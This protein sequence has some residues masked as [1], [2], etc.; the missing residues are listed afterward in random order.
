[1]DDKSPNSSVPQSN[2]DDLVKELSRP[3]NY[4]PAS[5]NGPTSSIP[6]Q[7]PKPIPQPAPAPLTPSMPSRPTPLPTLPPT[8]SV[9][10]SRGSSIPQPSTPVGGG[11][12]TPPVTPSVP[13][14][15]QS[16]IRT[17]ADDMAKIKAGQQPQGVNIPRKIDNIPTAPVTPVVPTTPVPMSPKSGPTASMPSATKSAPLSTAPNQS[18][19][20]KTPTP[21]PIPR[22]VMPP[23]TPSTRAPETKFDQKNQF[24]VPPTE[25]KP[26][27]SGSNSRNLIFVGIAVAVVL[28]GGLYWYFMIRTDQVA[29]E[30]PI[31]TFTPRPTATPNPDVLSTIFT[32]RGGTIV[33]PQSGDPTTA[34]SN[35]IGAQPV[36]SQTFVVMDISSGASSSSAQPLTIS[37]LLNRF[38][39]SYPPA[40]QT[41]LGQN[42]KFL[43]YG[44]KE[45]FDSKGQPATNTIPGSRFV[46]ISEI[47]SSSASILQGWESTMSND[48]AGIMGITPAKNIGPF[49]TTNYSGVSVHFKNFPYP[50]HSIDYALMQYNGKTYLIIAGSREAM[51]ATID[52]F[53]VLGK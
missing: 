44:Q 32:T 16:S 20:P 29:M 47:A 14:E 10:Q 50:D 7:A 6:N 1:M 43:L 15:Y 35:S 26:V 18:Q 27:G 23:A 36:T 4:P 8:P 52:S 19:T 45:S 31:P 51:F 5:A 28:L 34:F 9:S 39:V 33:L 38:V 17:M 46:I 11:I 49:L 24:Y 25:D 42:Y 41:A 2:I 37:G 22:P 30:S 3:Q 12:G 13:K 21:A 40:F 53:A 48:L